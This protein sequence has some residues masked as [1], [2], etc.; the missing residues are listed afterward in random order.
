MWIA[1]RTPSAFL[2]CSLSN[3]LESSFLP[4]SGIF[5]QL[6]WKPVRPKTFLS[7][8]TSQSWDY[9]LEQEASLVIWVHESEHGKSSNL[10]SLA[11]EFFKLA[12]EFCE[13]HP[14]FPPEGNVAIQKHSALPQSTAYI[15]LWSLSLSDLTAPASQVLGSKGCATTVQ[16]LRLNFYTGIPFL[17]LILC[18]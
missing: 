5:S 1:A 17:F 2:Y 16:H 7:L 13:S 3:H 6:G 9:R 10:L 8:P 12:C 14:H 15:G 18:L 11:P 4:E